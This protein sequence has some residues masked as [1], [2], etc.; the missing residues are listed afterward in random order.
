MLERC[1]GF[2]L[3]IRNIGD[4][5]QEEECPGHGVQKGLLQ[6]I[7]FEV[8][9]SNA[10]LVLSDSLNRHQPL[11]GSQE[12]GIQLIVG[13]EIEEDASHGRCNKSNQQEDD[14]PRLD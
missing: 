13:H 2:A 10:L 5:S 7:H 3:T 12:S 11:L 8:L 4:Q 6:L 14:L 9:V 1:R